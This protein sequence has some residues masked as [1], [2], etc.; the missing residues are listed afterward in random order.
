MITNYAELQSSV[1]SFP[2]REQDT[3]YVANT[4]EFISLA[5][6]GI[7]RDVRV[8]DMLKTQAGTM[9]SGAI[10]LPARFL[11]VRALKVD[12]FGVLDFMD[13]FSYYGREDWTYP[14]G[15][16][17]DGTRIL[18]AAGGASAYVLNYWQS[19]EAL[20]ASSDTNW[21][22]TNAPDVYL[23]GALVH[24]AVFLKDPTAAAG[25]RQLYDAAVSAINSQARAQQIAGPA[26]VRPRTYA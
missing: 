17:I 25:Y 13:Q 23:Y 3:A 8:L 26:R 22:L 14:A 16:T 21:L 18:V 11:A 19:Y 2:N 12:T 6:A 7:R 24:G 9:S 5:E 4:A 10:D 1:Q 15:Y 20:S